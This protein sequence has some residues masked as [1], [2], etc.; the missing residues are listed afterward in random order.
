[1]VMQIVNARGDRRLQ[2]KDW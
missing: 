1:M 2:T